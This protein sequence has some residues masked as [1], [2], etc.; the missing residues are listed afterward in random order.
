MPGQVRVNGLDRAF[1]AFGLGYPRPEAINSPAGRHGSDWIPRNDLQIL[2]ISTGHTDARRGIVAQPMQFER[3]AM[4]QQ[5]YVTLERTRVSG[6]VLA[7][8]LLVTGPAQAQQSDDGAEAAAQ[9]VQEPGATEEVIVTGQRTV[10]SLIR[11][12]GRETENFYM[13]L[14]EVLENEDFKVDCRTEYPAG[15][16]IATKVCRTGYQERLESRAAL[17]DIQNY[18]TTDEDIMVYEGARYQYEPEMLRMQREFGDAML[19]AVN[20]DPELNEA[21]WNLVGLKQA[22]DSYETPREQR[23]REREEAEAAE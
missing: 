17:S 7:L 22:V 6:V 8:A 10:R 12:A 5:C 11:E 4:R 19:Q 16:N 3:V 18:R 13:L 1:V 21:F 9:S 14:N 15:S 2:R 23:I 20:S